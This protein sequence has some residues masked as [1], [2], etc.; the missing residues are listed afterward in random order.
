MDEPP[1]SAKE[2]WRCHRACGAEVLGAV[3]ESGA[4]EERPLFLPT[5]PFMAMI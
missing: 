3:D 5:P 4:G 2:L 1:T